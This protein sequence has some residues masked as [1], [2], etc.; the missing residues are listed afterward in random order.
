MRLLAEGVKT[1]DIHEAANEKWMTGE[2]LR[3]GIE[4]GTS[5]EF[6]PLL[7]N[8]VEAV[9]NVGTNVDFY[10]GVFDEFGVTCVV[11]GETVTGIFG[12][13]IEEVEKPASDRADNRNSDEN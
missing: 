1:I 12:A 11:V 7:R 13:T 9:S 4:I 3:E 6:L 8:V 10:E 5:V 2:S